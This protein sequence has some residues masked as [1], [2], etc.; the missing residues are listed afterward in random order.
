MAE[1][2]PPSPNRE[3]ETQ[4]FGR[5]RGKPAMTVKEQSCDQKKEKKWNSSL[6]KK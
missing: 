3:D 1:E 2:H 6:K 5:L 4:A